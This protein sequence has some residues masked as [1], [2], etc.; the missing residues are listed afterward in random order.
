MPTPLDAERLAPALPR[1]LAEVAAAP[2]PDMALNNLERYAAAVDRSVFYRTLAEHPGAA[3][4]LARLGGASQFLADALRRRPSTLAWL[5][6]PSTMRVWLAEDVAEDLARSLA[7]FTSREARMNALR[8]FKYR[9]L[10]RIGARDLLG[11]ADLS[12]TTEELSRLADACLAEA[13]RMADAE[14]RGRHGAPLDTE[15]A[16]T[17]LAVVGMGKLGGE[18]LNY[19]SDIDLMFVYGADGQTAGGPEGAIPSGEYFARVARE[20]IAIVESAT[21][22]GYAFRVDMRLRPE[23]RVGAIALS[24]E[25]YR[26]Y[27]RER[28]ELWERQALLKARISAGDARV[29]APFMELVR[30]VVYRPGLDER[31]VPAIRTMKR[32]IDRAL[33]RRADEPARNVK[34]GHG[35]IREIEFLVQALQLLY[36]GDDP[37]LRERNTLKAL[38]RLTERGYLAPDLGRRLSH[39]LVH[40]RTTEHRLQILHEF[41]THTLPDDPSELGRLARRVGVAG[42]PRQAARVFVRLHRAITADVHRAFRDFFGER[43]VTRTRRRLPS[44]MALSATGFA[45]PE[46]ALQNLKLILEGRPLVPYAGALRA[47]LE[48]LLP[49]LLDALWKSPDPD[50]ALNQFERFLA[51]A[52]PRAGY[53]EL[54]AAQPEVL[55]G[56]VRLCA[57]GDLLTQLLIAQPELFGSLADPGAL[58]GRRTRAGFRAALAPVFDPGIEAAE[59]RDRLRRIKQAQELTVVWRYLLGVTSI[60]GYAR[61][62][63]A[64]AEATLDGGWLLALSA[65]VERHGVP[66]AADG[67]F[68]PAV[69]V[70]LGKLG[71]R[72]LTTGSDLDVLVT[73]GLPDTSEGMTDGPASVD[74]HTFYSGAVERLASALGDITAAGVAFAVDLRLRPGSKGSGFAAGLDALERYYV[75]HG[76]LWER[77]TLTRTRLILGDR[78]LARRTRAALRRLVYGAPLPERSLKEI[79][80]VRTRMEMELGKETRGRYHVKL[81]RGGLVDVEFLAQALALVH[82]AAHPDVR[83]ASTAGVLAALA[84]VGAL[85]AE[86]AAALADHYRFLRRV[87]AGLRLL[88]ARPADTLELAGPMPARVGTALGFASRD[89]F[90]AA[91]RERTGAVRAAYDEVFHQ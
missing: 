44:R 65:Q 76:D 80:E 20:V 78:G 62:M 47:A 4:L 22:D 63:T 35:G 51:A 84:R 52:G 60:E 31:V 67:R 66:R 75:E 24:L 43:P 23:G 27:H 79:A 2:D 82:G 53:I 77:Q 57:G 39:A 72:E 13:C 15:G 55:Q 12:V 74:A 10:L 56:V 54:L 68:I 34:L 90:L 40:L 58:V 83:R 26:A 42:T 59:Q 7:A 32:G 61:E 18:E 48:R 49:A 28:A 17:G 19:S 73:F 9:H 16:E 8:R 38:F 45:D 85:G 36:G 30:E 70:G 86:A 88:G 91:Y 69:L 11:D 25:G 14:V 50:E 5:L 41:Q 1:L 3:A 21:E 81:G 89:A 64:L 29:G 87:S 71:G 46:R 37:W 33:E 6:E